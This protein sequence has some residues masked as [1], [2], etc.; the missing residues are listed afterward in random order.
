MLP[1]LLAAAG[2][3]PLPDGPEARRQLRERLRRAERRARLRAYGLILPLL[4]F[5]L[6]TF[7]V[8]IGMMLLNSVHDPV[9]ADALPR[10]TMLLRTQPAGAQV[11][12]EQAPG[13]QI[14][15]ALAA[16]MKL[17]LEQQTA[18]QVASRL[19]FES[20]GLRSLFMRTARQVAATES[21]PWK[22]VFLTIDP[23]WGEPRIWS[24]LRQTSRRLN[25]DAWLHAVDLTRDEVGAIVPV[26]AEDRL[27]LDVFGRT[28]GMALTVTLLCVAIGYPL[29]WWMAHLPAR[30]SNLVMVM[31][32]LPFWTSLLV[33]TTAWVVLLQQEG[34]VNSALIGLGLIEQPLA[35]MF[36]RFGVVVA[37][38]HI[39]LPFMILPLSS[40]MRQ[41]PASHVRA[42]RSLGATPWTAF[43]R[44]YLPQSLPGISAGM[45]LVFILAI[46]YYITP[47]LLGGAGDQ[48]MSY[49]IADHLS[50][51]LNWGLAC[52]LGGLLLAGVMVLYVVYERCVGVANVRLG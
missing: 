3:A 20:G 33:R 22:D 48:M 51:S 46:G 8:P 4:L 21:G 15:A 29:S 41:I 6:L 26:V 23:A 42:A 31:V 18:S 40:V 12:G 44:V 39:L 30:T 14:Y 19:N 47:A 37:M 45:L 7:L 34:V 25:G 1:P 32:L 27:Y 9:V 17:A 50:R 35:L 24:V 52:A 43:R 38:T 10:L 11:P 49:F 28:L 36:N 13:E 2:A 5:T 16:D